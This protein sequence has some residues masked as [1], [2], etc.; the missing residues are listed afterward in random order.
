MRMKRLSVLSKTDLKRIDAASKNMLE[1]VG[2]QV[3]SPSVLKMLAKAGAKVDETAKLVR[4]PKKMVEKALSTVPSQVDLYDRSLKNKITLGGGTGA[5]ASGHNATFIVDSQTGRRRGVTR[6]DIANFSIIADSLPEMDVVGIQ[7]MPQ[8]VKPEAT[9][10]HAFAATVSNTS[11]HIF[12]SPESADVVRAILDIARAVSGKRDFLKASPVTC[13]LSPT[14][15]LMWEPGAVEGVV[16]CAKAGVPLCFLPQPFSG[17]TAPITIAGLLAQHNAETLSGIVIHQLVRPGAPVIWGSAWTT[18][19]MKK[20]SVIICSPEASVLR[21]AGS[22]LAAFYNIPS[23]TIG[24]DADA[25]AYDQQLGWEK[26][27]S[28][29]SALGSGVD[30]LVNAGM[31]GTGMTVSLEQLV[32]DAEI[33]SICRRFL[34]GMAVNETTL[35][36]DAIAEVGPAGNFMAS[37]HTLN[38]LRSGALWEE[39]I[40]NRYSFDNWQNRGGYDIMANARLRAREILDGHK[41]AALPASAQSAIKSIIESFERSH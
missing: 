19:D 8:D 33:I 17:M 27:M 13:Q 1:K 20:A 38:N 34:E 22:E 21:V 7:A 14:S 6:Q 35:G 12:F 24:P 15:P 31:F 2:V 4:F 28:T 39:K 3:H 10:I 9:L 5:V 26:M 18:F 36:L 40:S 23:H 37:T 16:E 32:I 29:L 11:K 41:A 25:H 30:L